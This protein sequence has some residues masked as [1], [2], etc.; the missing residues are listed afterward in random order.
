M[1]K[2][3][4]AL[5]LVAPI[6][7]AVGLI[8]LGY[9][10]YALVEADLHDGQGGEVPP[11]EHTGKKEVLA[12]PVESKHLPWQHPSDARALPPRSVSSSSVR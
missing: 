4:Q 8:A 6:L 10:A 11:Y 12:T 7:I 1:K 5:H 2:L 9:F 3:W